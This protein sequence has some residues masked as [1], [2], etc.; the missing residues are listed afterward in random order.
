VPE[1]PEAETIARGLRG[2]LQD[3]R[4]EATRVLRPDL[5]GEDPL[6]FS[7]RGSGWRFGGVGRRGKN[8]VLALHPPHR[9]PTPGAAGPGGGCD[10]RGR[11]E[12]DDIEEEPELRLVVHLGMSGRLLHRSYGDP[13]PP[14]SHPGVLFLLSDESEL[15]YHD[16]RRFGLLRWMDR[17]AFAEWTR[18]LGPEPLEESFTAE[19]LIEGLGR[20]TSPV[21]SWLLDQRRVAG[22]G[23]IY[24]LESL[25]L[26][27]IDP[28][29]P[30]HK[31]PPAAARRLHGAL[32]KVLHDAI[33]AQGTTLRDYR[34]AQGWEG[35]YGTALR[36]YGREGLPCPQCTTPIRRIVF[37]GRGSFLCPH[38]QPAETSEAGVRRDPRGPRGEIA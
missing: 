9:T 18:T 26:A 4:L 6:D 32:G 14:P 13:S 24:A 11:R 7:R 19:A 37:G 35:S 5:I 1:L 15:I 28:R 8:L 36:V 21:R 33:L 10:L 20:S 30:A 25:F 16:P 12:G 2:P 22:I 23:N 34:T 27:G 3:L 17:E 29:T 38:C 31:V